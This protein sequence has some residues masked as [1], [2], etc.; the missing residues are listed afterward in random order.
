MLPKRKASSSV[1]DEGGA[2]KTGPPALGSSSASTSYSGPIPIRE[3]S[4][5]IKCLDHRDALYRYSKAPSRL[6]Q[7]RTLHGYHQGFRR[8]ATLGTPSTSRG[9]DGGR[10]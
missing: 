6:V 2:L 10:G 3:C 4:V 1:R 9:R 5:P 8:C 7:D